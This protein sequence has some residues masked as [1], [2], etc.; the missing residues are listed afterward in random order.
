[1][2]WELKKRIHE[3]FGTQYDFAIASGISESRLSK[4]LR[5]RLRPSKDEMA[6]MAKAL[7][8]KKN[9]VKELVGSVG[10]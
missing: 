2:L 1:M 7:G 10:K 5:G 8:L 9:E 3:N 6:K 4:F